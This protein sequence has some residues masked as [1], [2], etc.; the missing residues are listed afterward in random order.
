M[1]CCLQAGPQPSVPTVS[2]CICNADN[3]RVIACELFPKHTFR[4]HLSMKHE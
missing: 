2:A 3:Q 1:V 4:T